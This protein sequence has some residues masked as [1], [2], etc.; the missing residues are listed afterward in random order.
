MQSPISIREA[1]APGRVWS[2]GGGG[3]GERGGGCSAHWSFY[4]E[5]H[6]GPRITL[7]ARAQH[8]A[9]SGNQSPATGSGNQH[10]GIPSLPHHITPSSSQHISEQDELNKREC[11]PKHAHKAA[12]ERCPVLVRWGWGS[13][14]AEP[15]SGGQTGE[16][17]REGGRGAGAGVIA[18]QFVQYVEGVPSRPGQPGPRVSEDSLDI[19]GSDGGTMLGDDVRVLANL[20]RLHGAPA[21]G[22]VQRRCMAAVRDR[23]RPG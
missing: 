21:T 19:L 2:A 5:L 10:P 9:R 23:A 7:H 12:R 17:G 6:V 1:Q 3:G 8:D 20:G 14:R 4:W 15:C 13:G 16:G 18:S 11:S 22:P